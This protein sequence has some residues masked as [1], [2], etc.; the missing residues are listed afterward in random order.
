MPIHS[1]LKF[2]RESGHQLVDPETLGL[3]A[4]SGQGQFVIDRAR[5][6]LREALLA[7]DESVAQQVVVDLYLAQIPVYRI[8]DEVV[9]NVFADI[10]EMWACEE[11]AVYQE[12][13]GCEIALRV[14][15]EL[16]SLVT[17]SHPDGPV[18]IGGTIAG[19]N[20]TLPTA[21]VE[22][23]L[24]E[25]RWRATS[26]G[27]SLPFETLERAVSDTQPALFWLSVSHI[28]D[29]ARFVEEFRRFRVEAESHGT[30]VVLGGRA[31]DARLLDAVGRPT[32]FET[33]ADLSA[34]ARAKA[35]K[36]STGSD[37]AG[38]SN[39]A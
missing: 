20:Y 35:E 11:A 12:R 2:L 36:A 22:L 23:V 5:D 30:D 24:R 16:R 6:M 26:L 13:R 15:L 37:H 39:Q 21:I 4:T 32:Y 9:T 14:L 27:C 1:V 38:E 25:A 19:D 18:A 28:E 3:P 7:G 34:H 8:C 33:F 10:G 17:T 31:L 29:E